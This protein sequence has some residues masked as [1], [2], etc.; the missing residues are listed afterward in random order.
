MSEAVALRRG[1]ESD[2][3]ALRSVF[4]RSVRRIASADYSTEQ[5]EA[6]APLGGDRA[7]WIR[8]RIDAN[9]WVAVLDGRVA[10]F[11]DIDVESGRIGMLFVDP[12]SSRLGI[13]SK[14][15]RRNL[16]E[17]RASLRRSVSVEA[18]IT[19]RPLFE[20]HGFVVVKRQRVLRR[21]TYLRN[22]VMRADIRDA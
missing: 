12:D 6:W 17:A 5:V 13:G 14:L 19:A 7:G 1:T 3:E 20:T 4:L 22:Y 16:D 10:G 2:G 15:I 18:S 8:D 9:T 21:N 11:S